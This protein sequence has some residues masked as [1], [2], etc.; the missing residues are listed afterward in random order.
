MEVSLICIYFHKC[1]KLVGFKEPQ[2]SLMSVRFIL[3]S[4]LNPSVGAL[5]MSVSTNT[6]PAKSN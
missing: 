6:H 2:S 5:G 4:V 1:V 3:G